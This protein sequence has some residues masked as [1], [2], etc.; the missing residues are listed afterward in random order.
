MAILL[1]NQCPQLKPIG[2]RRLQLS[3][4]LPG[5]ASQV[6]LGN[7]EKFV[8]IEVTHLSRHTEPFSPIANVFMIAPP[9]QLIHALWTNHPEDAQ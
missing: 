1:Q 5:P 8:R 4:P 7:L 6:E 3:E 9:E 2:R